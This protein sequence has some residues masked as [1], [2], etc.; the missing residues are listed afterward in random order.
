[1]KKVGVV[2][3]NYKEYANKYLNA[4]RDSLRLQSYQNFIVYIVDNASSESSQVYLKESYPEAIILP[5]EDG[6]YCAANNLG[7]NQAI[8]D[9]CDYLVSANMD[10]EFLVDWL[11]ELVLALDNNTQAGIAQSLILLDPKTPTEKENPK[12]NTTGNLIHFLL[13]GFTSNYNINLSEISLENY[14]ELNGYASGC[15]FIIRSEIFQEIGGYNNDYYMYHDDLDI[16]LKVKLAGYK[17]ILASKSVVFHKYEF[18]RS[19]RMLYYMERNRALSFFSIYPVSVI[20]LLLPFW[21]AM[22]LG[23]LLFSILGGW[24]KTK[25]KVD[26]YFFKISTWR[27]IIKNRQ[28]YKNITKA[29]KKECFNNFVGRIE[30]QEIDNPIL[31]YLVNPVFSAYW[32]LV[33]KII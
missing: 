32:S 18:E 13:F 8:L 3:V 23:M 27:L 29:D 31:K 15:S 10:T 28:H 30:F 21:I 2:L 14:Q 4:C 33:K 1:M 25:L 26:A 12:I 16:S 24:F 22:S 19:V 20:I 7:M 17:L 11:K 9:G 6:N 5:R